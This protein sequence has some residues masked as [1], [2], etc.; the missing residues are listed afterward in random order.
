MV[1]FKFSKSILKYVF[2][3]YSVHIYDIASMAKIHKAQMSLNG[4]EPLSASSNKNY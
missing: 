3:G 2:C 1:F 4:M